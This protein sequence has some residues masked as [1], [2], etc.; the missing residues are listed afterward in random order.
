MCKSSRVKQFP[1]DSEGNQRD[2]GARREQA[3]EKKA[4]FQSCSKIDTFLSHHFCFQQVNTFIF[5]LLCSPYFFRFHSKCAI[6]FTFTSQ[7]CA[8]LKIE[9]PTPDFFTYSGKGPTMAFNKLKYPV[10]D[11]NPA[12]R[13]VRD[14]NLWQDTH[15]LSFC[16]DCAWTGLHDW[17]EGYLQCKENIS[18]FPKR[19]SSL[20]TFFYSPRVIVVGRC[21]WERNR[22]DLGQ[23]HIWWAKNS[24]FF[25]CC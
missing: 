3:G 16:V 7:L 21:G 24:F 13:K 25:F 1:G 15:F 12:Y 4:F 22:E 20:D 2:K 9:K 14:Q 5:Q 8:G 19:Y 23:L 17:R 11:W 6:S 18:S 10:K